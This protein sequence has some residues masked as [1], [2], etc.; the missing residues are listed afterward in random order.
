MRNLNS[1]SDTRNKILAPYF[2]ARETGGKK[3][4]LH[5]RGANRW[6]GG[7]RHFTAMPVE[8]LK[9]LVKEKFAD[10]T[11]TQ[12]GS[13]SI[14]SFIKFMER[15]PDFVLAHGYAVSR[16]KDDYRISVEGVEG[17][18]P[19][20]FEERTEFE[21]EFLKFTAGADEMELNTNG[22]FRVWYD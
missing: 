16:Q 22:Y 18:I 11:E 1:D 2:K 17:H 14:A 3:R 19:L 6:Q 5:D 9:F 13:P 8:A 4:Q 10:P 20:N 12:N 21:S 7:C 15:W